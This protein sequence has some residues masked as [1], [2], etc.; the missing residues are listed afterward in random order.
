MPPGGVAPLSQ[1]QCTG[2]ASLW[3]AADNKIRLCVNATFKPVSAQRGMLCSSARAG[4]DAFE[5]ALPASA[6]GPDV[7]NRL[8]ELKARVDVFQHV[9]DERFLNSLK[10]GGFCRERGTCAP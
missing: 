9:W 6:T 2:L 4:V 7:Y 3:R 8:G 1:V 10:P 5:A